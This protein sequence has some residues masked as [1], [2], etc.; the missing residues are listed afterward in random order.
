MWAARK[1]VL[2]RSRSV[3]APLSFGIARP[4]L[5]IPDREYEDDALRNVFRHE[6]MHFR[7]HDILLKWFFL[8]VFSV[9]WFNPFVRCF[10]KE[11]DRVCKL[12]CDEALLKRMNADEKRR[13]GET[14]LTIA[15]NS[16]EAP[17]RMV[18]GFSEGKKNLKERLTQIMSFKKRSKAAMALALVPVLILCGCAVALGPKA[19]ETPDT[20]AVTVSSV[21]E[22]LAAIAPDAEIH[23][24]AGTYNLTEAASYGNDDA[25]SYYWL[26]YGFENEYGLFIENVD[27]LTIIGDNAEILTVPRSA[28][29]LTFR[30]CDQLTLQGLTVGH[31]EAA[32]ACEGGVIRL[33]GCFGAIVD[34]CRLYG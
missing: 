27:N 12:S 30:N 28:N 26:S 14:L 29:V 1:P 16:C 7:R 33:E 13:Y 32:Q 10:R 6:I 23:L 20:S 34:H 19:D 3:P 18:T 8:L 9:H 21:D 25:G 15:E 24:A 22:L 31:T 4:V 5:V 17:C 11:I 2:K